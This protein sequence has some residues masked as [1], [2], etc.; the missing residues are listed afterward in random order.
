MAKTKGMTARI[1]DW[2][3]TALA[4]LKDNEDVDVFKKVAA[5]IGQLDEKGLEGFLALSPFALVSY[6]PINPEREGDYDLNDKLRFSVLLGVESKEAGVA[7]RGDDTH[8]GGSR[9][10]DLVI[11]AIEKHHPGS[12][13]DCDEFYFAG[14]TEWADSA[15]KYA[16]ELFFVA[17]W[18]R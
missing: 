2:L 1:E 7:K 8:L 4:A 5:Y 13:F 9:I 17:N 10:R 6:Y 14:E 3:V 12:S 11:D 16:T 15:K 18:L